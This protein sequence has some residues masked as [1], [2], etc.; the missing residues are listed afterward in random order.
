MPVRRS[1]HRVA[2]RD[3]SALSRSDGSTG[4][5]QE[6]NPV[7]EVDA[8][9]TS[10]ASRSTLLGVDPKPDHLGETW[11]A[12][13][14]DA[15]VAAAYQFRPPYPDQAVEHVVALLPHGGGR[16]LDV[17]CGTGDLA[18]PL[19]ARGIAV[20]AVDP[21]E[22]MIRAGRARRGGD[23]SALR[24]IVGGIETAPIV[25]PYALAT[26]AESLHWTDW[27]VALPRLRDALA[28]GGRLVLLTRESLAA[29]WADALASL[30]PRFSTNR[31]FRRYDLVAELTARR[32]FAEEGRVTTAPVEVHQSVGDYVESFHSR[33][34]FSR[35]RM[36]V[37]AASEFDA[38]LAAAVE[39]DSRDG[40]VAV[41][42]QCEIV[43]GRPL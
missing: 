1:V 18:I 4:E 24:W 21:S 43:W 17:G 6:G 39:R 20:D 10:A 25:P 30:I 15:E 34:G 12:Q 29:S 41:T 37:E 14:A 33:N 32:L 40:T 5:A 28:P 38:A 35:A 26:A 13:F 7:P 2:F 36:T 19:A 16:I 22:S 23:A 3:R 9:T 42:T 11:A 8:A 27:P 31:A